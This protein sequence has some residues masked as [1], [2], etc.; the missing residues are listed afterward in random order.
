MIEG[1][2][3]AAPIDIV[4]PLDGLEVFGH[5]ASEVSAALVVRPEAGRRARVARAGPDQIGGHRLSRRCRTRLGARVADVE[6]DLQLVA[7]EVAD[8]RAARELVLPVV[9]DDAFV[10]VVGAAEVIPYG[11][12]AALERQD[13]SQWMTRGKWRAE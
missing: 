13:A 10:A 1:E 8:V 5:H 3:E 11:V 4:Q 6:V 12:A 7:G 9:A 2:S